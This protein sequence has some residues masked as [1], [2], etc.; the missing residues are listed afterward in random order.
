MPAI[1]KSLKSL[2]CGL[3][4]LCLLNGNIVMSETVRVYVGT[5]TRNGKSEGIYQFDLDAKTGQP[6]APRAVARVTNPSF[7]AFDPKHQYLYSVAEVSDFPGADGPAGGVAAFRIDPKSGDLSPL[8]EQLSGGAGPCHVSVDATGKNVL[9]ANYG[10]G[11]CG[12]LPVR[13]DG[14]LGKM[15]S[16]HQHQGS[17]VNPRR[18]EGPH[19]HSINVSPDNQF[20]MVADL[21]LDQ[22]LVY[23]FDPDQHTL[24]PHD[25]PS[26]STH[27]GAGP[28]HFSFHPSGKFAYNCNEMQ[29]T[30]TAYAYDAQQGVLTPLQTITTLPDGGAGDN[31]STAECLVHPSGKFVYIS[32][33][34]HDSL[35][36]FQVQGDGTLKPA[37]HAPTLG[38]IPRNFG[39]TPDG[40]F[41]LAANQNSDTIVVFR[42]DLKSGALTPTGDRIE[43]PSP[44]CVRMFAVE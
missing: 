13:E 2:I 16:F 26:V 23:K 33:R 15:S 29:M 40:R 6:S 9:V 30:A 24:T 36:I 17:S 32:N 34:G 31:D 7:V 3:F 20:A 11:S 14:S 1:C 35:A 43:V 25:P 4:S 41:V 12:C 10:G 37:G 8:N 28:R 27:P 22:I 44:V 39:I 42:V 19:A 38:E 21:G 5:Y 18:Q